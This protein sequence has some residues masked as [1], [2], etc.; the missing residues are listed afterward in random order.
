MSAALAPAVRALAAADFGAL[1]GRF[2]AAG[3]AVSLPGAGMLHVR[4]VAAPRASVL[5]SVGVHGD[6]TG[7]LEMLAH[8]LAALA[9]QPRALAVDLMV[10]VGNLAA[11]QAGRRYLDADLNRMFR[12]ARG[13]LAGAAEARRADALIGATEA[14]F[15]G[16]GAARWHLDLHAAIRPSLYPTFAIVPELIA[17]PARAALTQWLAQAQVGAVILNPRSAGTYS[18]YSAEHCGSAAATLELGR[19]GALGFND[20]SL[21]AGVARALD[22]LLR[23]ATPAAAPAAPEVFRVAQEIIKS[24]AGLRM[25][26]GPDTPNFS[27]LPAGAV[28]A[29]DGAVRYTVG[30]SEE[31][32]VFPNPDVQVGLRAAL[33]IRKDT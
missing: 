33:M 17:A 15:R 3:C 5:V 6:E 23:G 19:V 21:F 20:L 27:A 13:E 16:A 25:A 26:F 10:C 22:G 8:L 2:Q 31:R 24:S 4:P 1:A 9:E 12:P 11:L 18:Y 14:F 32:I 28:I 30:A 7:P 29:T